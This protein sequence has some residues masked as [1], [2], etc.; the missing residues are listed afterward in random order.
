LPQYEYFRIRD[1]LWGT[2][3]ILRKL[4]FDICVNPEYIPSLY[5]YFFVL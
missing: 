3:Q 5:L 4:K 1:C 2:I